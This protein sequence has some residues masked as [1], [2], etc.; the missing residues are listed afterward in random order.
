M[1]KKYGLKA[2]VTGVVLM[3]G[4]SGAQATFMPVLDEFWVV[5]NGVEVF[6][7]SFSAGAVP[8]S[9]PEDGI[10]GSGVTYTMTGAAGMVS[11]SLGKLTMDPSLGVAQ[12]NPEGNINIRTEARRQRTTNPASSAFLGAQDS[13]SVNTLYDLSS[14]PEVAASG[15]GVRLEDFAPG[16]ANGGN[17]VVLLEVARGRTSGTLGIIFS[18]I[19][20]GS[21]NVETM[22]FVSL[23]G[24]LD[25]N[26]TAEQIQLTLTKNANTSEVAGFFTI[27]DGLGGVL[28]TQ[29]LDN[30]GNENGDTLVI[31]EGEDFT[32]AG[33]SARTQVIVS[34]PAT[35]AILLLSAFGLLT[36]KR[37][38]S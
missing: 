13:F 10:T 37:R 29:L 31:Y 4:I 8:A 36:A 23:Q 30:I 22:D 15:F 33:F 19:D 18:D 25:S 28:H 20:F 21:G 12:F 38:R 3:T 6:R 27:F 24:L 35:A 7:D 2:V 26:P 17:D 16:N 1:F 14:L 5:K 11:E 9:G 32:R 34:E